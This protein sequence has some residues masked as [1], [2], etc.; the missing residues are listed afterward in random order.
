MQPKNPKV[1]LFKRNEYGLTLLASINN[2]WL[3]KNEAISSLRFIYETFLVN[4]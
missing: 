2:D 3:L 1:L 4:E